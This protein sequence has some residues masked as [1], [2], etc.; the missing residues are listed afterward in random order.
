MRLSVQAGT[1]SKFVLLTPVGEVEAI[2]VITAVN[3]GKA[4][5]L[6]ITMDPITAVSFAASILTFI[7]FGYKI[8]TGAL[9]I[10]KSGSTSDNAHTSTVINYF[11]EIVKPLSE[12]PP[13]KSEHEEALKKLAEEC[14]QVS[15]ELVKLL[16]KLTTNPGCSLWT[17]ARVSLRSMR[18]KGEV[19]D[20]ENKLDKYRS[21]ILMRLVLILR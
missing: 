15:Q 3:I 2:I 7:D 21:Q 6:S 5:I 17:S 1:P 9:E 14:K 12:H 8:V 18:K 10:V 16:D 13:G 19:V 4:S 11:H 20:L